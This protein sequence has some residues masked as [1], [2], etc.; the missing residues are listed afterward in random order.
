MSE[1]LIKTRVIQKHDTTENWAKATN[2]IPKS[3]ELI[4]YD[5][6]AQFNYERLKL[7]DGKTVVSDLPFYGGD[8]SD[9]LTADKVTD[10]D[11]VVLAEEQS[12]TDN[13]IA[14]IDVATDEE[15]VEMLAEQKIV[16]PVID[17]A[18]Y[19]YTDNN[20]NILIL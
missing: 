20:E 5:T 18:G 14:N 1:K 12:Y 16:E 3:G 19:I 8:L 11:A 9:Y 2:F 13:A 6:D 17:A 7:G 15:V 4:V 10:Q